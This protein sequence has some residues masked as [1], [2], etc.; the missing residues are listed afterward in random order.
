MLAGR[1]TTLPPPPSP[2]HLDTAAVRPHISHIRF[3]LSYTFFDSHVRHA[4]AGSAAGFVQ[5]YSR[6]SC[7]SRLHRIR[8]TIVTGVAWC[9]RHVYSSH[10]TRSTRTTFSRLH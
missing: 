1:H 5:L 6:W 3:S 2:Q 7:G 8:T 4:S 10:S 9:R